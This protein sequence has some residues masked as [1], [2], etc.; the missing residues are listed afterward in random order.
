MQVSSSTL[1]SL[2]SQLLD[3]RPSEIICEWIITE[4][5]RILLDT[6]YNI[7]K[8]GH[9]LGFDD[10]SYFVKYLKKKIPVFLDFRKFNLKEIS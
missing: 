2:T 9:C 4:A 10:H 7:S 5:K 6:N 1:S 3:K 8:I